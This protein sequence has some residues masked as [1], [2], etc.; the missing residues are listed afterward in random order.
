MTEFYRLC[1]D[2][3]GPHN[4]P[5]DLWRDDLRALSTL[6]QR[7]AYV[8]L[9]NLTDGQPEHWRSGTTTLAGLSEY[10]GPLLV[11]LV[12][13][14][15]RAFRWNL[16]DSDVISEDAGGQAAAYHEAIEEEGEDVTDELLALHRTGQTT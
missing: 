2:G 16:E 1:R 6:P 11:S 4:H 15:F 13:A 9:D 5:L 3:F 8:T 7:P 10:F 14:G 12:N